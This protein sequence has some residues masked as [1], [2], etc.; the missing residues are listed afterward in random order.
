[1]E[2]SQEIVL[3][4]PPPE[5]VCTVAAEILVYTDELIYRHK[6]NREDPQLKADLFD[7]QQS[8]VEVETPSKE[9]LRKLYYKITNRLIKLWK[10]SQNDKVAALWPPKDLSFSFRQIEIKAFE[11]L[12][13]SPSEESILAAANLVIA[14]EFSSWRENLSD[15]DVYDVWYAIR[16]VFEQVLKDMGVTREIALRKEQLV[17]ISSG[18]MAAREIGKTKKEMGL[19][20]DYEPF[21]IAI[22]EVREHLK[23]RLGRKKLEELEE[24][25]MRLRC[26]RVRLVE[27]DTTTPFPQTSAPALQSQALP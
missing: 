15:L 10:E 4:A 25:T 9:E 18:H 19:S 24:K 13:E 22:L 12:S 17:F 1:M 27:E 14:G 8:I 16:D 11:K 23:S 2:Q 26:D 21:C 7:L 20:A 5:Y 3:L 6:L